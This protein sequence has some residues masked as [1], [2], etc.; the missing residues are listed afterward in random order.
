[1]NKKLSIITVVYNDVSKIN[2]TIE[3]V[4]A[5]KKDY[6]EYIIIDGASTDGTLEEIYKYENEIDKIVSEKDGGIYNAMNKGIEL[7]EGD[8]IGI[9]NSGD[10]FYDNAV[11]L[12]YKN[13]EKYGDKYLY[14]YSMNIIKDEEIK[15]SIIRTEEDININGRFLMFLNHPSLFVP[16]K[17]Y[18]NY[19]LYDERFKIGA[20]KD[21]VYRV[22]KEGINV[23]FFEDFTTKMEAG[24]I[25]QQSGSFKTKLRENYLIANKLWSNPFVKYPRLFFG[26]LVLAYVELKM[27]IKGKW[28]YC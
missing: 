25:S 1:M 22:L 14:N 23:L 8:I 18:E 13:Y 2:R 16:K 27:M 12:V 28:K 7:S 4:L 19:G 6:V 5:Q 24:G 3:S 17:I 9:L 11:E 10:E 15:K 20:D 26:A 21:F